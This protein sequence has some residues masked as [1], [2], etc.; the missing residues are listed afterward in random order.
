MSSPADLSTPPRAAHRPET[1][2]RHTF[3]R[4]R[5][6]HA[7]SRRRGSTN[8]LDVKTQPCDAV[9]RETRKKDEWMRQW[10]EWLEKKFKRTLCTEPWLFPQRCSCNHVIETYGAW[11][12]TLFSTMCCHV[13]AKTINVNYPP[14]AWCVTVPWFRCLCR[15]PPNVSIHTK[16]ADAVPP[17]GF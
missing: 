14:R 4:T 7:G 16:H 10:K 17:F 11:T 3:G 12:F 1:E 15:L 8:T 5:Y 13:W 2:L 9:F 6:R